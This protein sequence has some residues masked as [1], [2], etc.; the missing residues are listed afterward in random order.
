MSSCRMLP[1]GITP[2]DGNTSAAADSMD[3]RMRCGRQTHAEQ[4]YQ[5]HLL[6]VQYVDGLVGH[7][8]TRLEQ[9]GILDEAI[10]VVT[11]DHGV[12][13]RGDTP[14]RAIGDKNAY[15]VGLVPLFIKAPHQSSGVVD[16]TPSRAI[17]VLPTVAAFLGIELPWLH[18]GQ[19]LP[20]S[21]G[22]ESPLAVP[23]HLGGEV[24]LNHVADGVRDATEYAVLRYS[25]LA[26]DASIP[27][28]LV[29]TTA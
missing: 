19:P 25:E 11:A 10:V 27:M 18:Q 12:S 28:P 16:T 14:R 29:T 7:L 3:L 13:F 4:A 9:V 23:A 17:D 26:K 1:I 24:E 6:Q 15:E 22:A 21:P 20:R 2:R 5:R 8:L